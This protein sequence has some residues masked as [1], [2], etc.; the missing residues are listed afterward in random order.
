LFDYEEGPLRPADLTL[1]EL[2][3]N[4]L[5]LLVLLLLLLLH[6]PAVMPRLT[7]RRVLC[8]LLT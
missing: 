6:A 2:M 4:V 5:L 8:A 1:L 3:V 7:T